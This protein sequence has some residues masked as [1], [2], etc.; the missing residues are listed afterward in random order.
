MHKVYCNFQ[1]NIRNINGVVMMTQT[2]CLSGIAGGIMGL[3]EAWG[4]GIRRII[5]FEENVHTLYCNSV[6]MIQT[7][8]RS[9]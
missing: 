6:C 9:R 7:P 4:S 8:V 1:M 5:P 3:V 2:D